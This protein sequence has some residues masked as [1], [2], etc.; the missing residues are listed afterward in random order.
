M[1]LLLLLLPLG[2]FG[3]DILQCE[4]SDIINGNGFTPSGEFRWYLINK[5]TKEITFFNEE[6]LRDKTLEQINNKQWDVY[7]YTLKETAEELIGVFDNSEYVFID[8]IKLSVIHYKTQLDLW[9]AFDYECKLIDVDELL[10][11]VKQEYMSFK[12]SLKL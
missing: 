4:Q 10:E 11:N 3:N 2:L 1:R 12:L 6:S 7:K 8:R 5:D 9:Y